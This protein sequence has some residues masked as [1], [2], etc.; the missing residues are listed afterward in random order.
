MSKCANRNT[1]ILVAE[2]VARLASFSKEE[3][4]KQACKKHLSGGAPKNE[5][6]DLHSSKNNVD[7]FP[8]QT[9]KPLVL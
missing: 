9:E 2:P 4:K 6:W 1:K 5:E 7:S 8:S 3:E